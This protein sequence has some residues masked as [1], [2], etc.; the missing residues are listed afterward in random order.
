MLA[1]RRLRSS[2]AFLAI[3]GAGLITASELA[4]AQTG[5]AQEGRCSSSYRLARVPLDW[6]RLS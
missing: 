3:V 5:L 6:D 1:D 2:R 4:H